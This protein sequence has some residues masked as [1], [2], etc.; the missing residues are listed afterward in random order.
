MEGHTPA[1]IQDGHSKRPLAA[2]LRVRLLHIAE[3]SH[4]L[5]AWHR[6]LIRRCVPL[7]SDT[8]LVYEEVG[9]GCTPRL[10]VLCLI[11]HRKCVFDGGSGQGLCDLANDGE[12]A[13]LICDQCFTPF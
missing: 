6:L 5:L 2:C 4:E 11:C 3:V 9:I 12:R 7:C 8:A 1:N 10:H 13:P